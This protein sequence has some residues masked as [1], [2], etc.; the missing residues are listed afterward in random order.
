MR[1][2][3]L[4]I[5]AW[6]RAFIRQERHTAPSAGSVDR[7]THLGTLANKVTLV[8]TVTAIGISIPAMLQ[9]SLTWLVAAYLVYWAGDMLDGWVARRLAEE[10]QIGAV[11]D[12]VSDRACSA[13]LV[14]GLAIM[15][16]HLWVALVIFL[17]QF[18]VVDCVL[19]LAFLQWDLVS[20]NYFYRVDHRVWLLNWSPVAK[21]INTVGV[22]LAVMLGSLSLATSLATAQLA[23]KIWSSRRVLQLGRCASRA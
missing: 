17:V 2:T 4:G 22:V 9:A 6:C 19:S 13:V 1:D 14:C 5:A 20:P 21:S 18:M 3:T 8:R 7:W 15:Q 16:P 23:L 10:T 12:I 11:L